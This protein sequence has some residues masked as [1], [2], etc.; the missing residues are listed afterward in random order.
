[1]SNRKAKHLK[2]KTYVSD[3]PNQCWHI[4]GYNKLKSYGFPIHG[5]VD[6]WSRE[7][8]W[9]NVARSNNK[10]KRIRQQIPCGDIVLQPLQ[11][12]DF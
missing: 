12:Q 7:V 8:L 4:D 1:M 5:C 6:G 3:G 10:P 11:K 2:L 9:P